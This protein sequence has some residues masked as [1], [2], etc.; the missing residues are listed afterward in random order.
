MTKILKS[1]ISHL[2]VEARRCLDWETCSDSGLICGDAADPE[3]VTS[4]DGR[5]IQ[6]RYRGSCAAIRFRQALEGVSRKR[7]PKRKGERESEA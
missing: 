2:L 1:V 5:A 6:R 7:K 3:I 4:F